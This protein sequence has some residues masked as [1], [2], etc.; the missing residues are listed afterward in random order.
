MA[1]KPA[2]PIIWLACQS[3]NVIPAFI[4]YN[5]VGDGLAHC[6]AVAAPKLVLFDADLA[7]SVR[8]VAAVVRD[9]VPGTKFAKWTDGFCEGG[10]KEG[11]EQVEGELAVDQGTLL[12]MSV[13][14]IPDKFR[15]GITWQ[16]PVCFIYTSG[17]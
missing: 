13:E 6:V 11:G 15:N 4:N 16:S 17:T 2:Y 5:L 8:D 12:N 10:E 14:R 7:K 9:K 1:N 3:I